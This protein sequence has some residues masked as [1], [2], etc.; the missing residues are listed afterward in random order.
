MSLSLGLD[1]AGA[2]L[3]EGVAR[4][5]LSDDLVLVGGAQVE[6]PVRSDGPRRLGVVTQH[7]QDGI[8]DG[9]E[10]LFQRADARRQL[11]GFLASLAEGAP[12]VVEL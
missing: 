9:H 5:S 1:L 3:D 6:L 7:S 10:V 4:R 8:E 2:A 12:T 11:T